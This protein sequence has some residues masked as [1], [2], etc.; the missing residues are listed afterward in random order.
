MP[1]IT[2]WVQYLRFKLSARERSHLAHVRRVSSLI[3]WYKAT[4][5]RAITPRMPVLIADL[6]PKNPFT[7]SGSHSTIKNPFETP[8]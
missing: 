2:I 7:K 5:R 4:L 8:R 6:C 1:D 3:S